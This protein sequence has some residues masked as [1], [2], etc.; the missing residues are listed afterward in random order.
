MNE[1]TMFLEYF[2]KTAHVGAFELVGEID[3]KG[4]RGDGVLGRVGAVANNDRIAE[5]FNAHFI[6]PQVAEIR[7]GLC[8]L[9]GVG[10]GRDLFQS[11]TTLTESW[12]WAKGRDLHLDLRLN[13]SH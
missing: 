3:G 11:M 13:I 12:F 5:S 7:R 9:K 10:L 8:V 2:D 6:D 1:A 4:D